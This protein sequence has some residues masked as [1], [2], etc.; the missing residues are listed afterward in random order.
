MGRESQRASL[1]QRVASDPGLTLRLGNRNLLRTEMSKV[2]DRGLMQQH[3]RLTHLC[4]HQRQR[5]HH[6][7]QSKRE[8][9]SMPSCQLGLSDLWS[10]MY[11]MEILCKFDRVPTILIMVQSQYITAS[12]QKSS[13]VFLSSRRLRTLVDG[14]R[15]RF[16]GIDTPEISENQPFAKEAKAYVRKYCHKKE[17]YITYDKF[18]NRKDKFGRL[19][20]FVWAYDASN[21]GYICVNEGVV[22][23]GL[24]TVYLPRKDAKLSNLRKLITLQKEARQAKRGIWSNFVDYK[25]L[26]TPNGAAYHVAGCRHNNRNLRSMMASAAADSGLHPCRTC[27]ADA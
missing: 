3:A 19:L 15:V 24:A 2:A 8:L 20:A 22:A 11:T 7:R 13:R 6:K 17:I 10:E 9:R 21:G 27:L 1:S 4:S 23:E 18:G 14:Q 25:V 16:L 26:V 5:R 12:N